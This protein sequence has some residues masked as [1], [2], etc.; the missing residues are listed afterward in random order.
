[1]SCRYGIANIAAARHGAGR[2]GWMAPPPRRPIAGGAHYPSWADS[3]VNRPKEDAMRKLLNA[4]RLP[5]AA[6][7]LAHGGDGTDGQPPQLK[8]HVDNPGQTPMP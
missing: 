7:S 5:K 2:R 8:Q 4:R 6:L 3:T 1:M